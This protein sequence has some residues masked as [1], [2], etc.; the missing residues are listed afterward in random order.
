M[1]LRS[2][3][4]ESPYGKMRDRIKER[5]KESKRKSGGKR[6]FPYR[7]FLSI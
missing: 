1:K 2:Q 7:Y 5:E 4:S 3:Y 6:R